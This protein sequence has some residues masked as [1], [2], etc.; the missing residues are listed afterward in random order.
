VLVNFPN[1]IY[2]PRNGLLLALLF[3][4]LFL[5]FRFSNALRRAFG[6]RNA[7]PLWRIIRIH[8]VFLAILFGF[9]WLAS[10]L[11]PFLPEWMTETTRPTSKPD[12]VSDFLFF[13]AALGLHFAERLW[14]YAQSGPLNLSASEDDPPGQDC[15]GRGTRL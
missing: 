2:E 1:H 3:T 9:M 11:E 15:D 13:A 12:S 4:A 10:S 6:K 14:L 8:S 7:V 5:T